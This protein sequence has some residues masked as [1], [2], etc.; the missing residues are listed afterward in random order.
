MMLI[1]TDS[2]IAHIPLEVKF[3]NSDEPY[4]IRTRLG[5]AIRGP[6]PTMKESNDININ[7][8]ESRDML[9]QQQ[10][11]RL[12]T[13]DFND[14]SQ[15]VKSCMSVEDKNA[16]KSM[17]S[18][19]TR[20]DGHYKIGLPWRDGNS[21]FVN[22]IPLAQA[23]LQQLKRKLSSDNNLHDMYR[24][25]VNGY[26]ANGYSSDVDYMVPEKTRVW[27]TPHH[28]VTNVHNASETDK[29][30]VW[31]HGPTFLSKG[32]E[33][34]PKYSSNF[35]PEVSED[36]VEVKRYGCIFSCLTSRAVHLEVTHSLSTDSFIAAS[37]RFISR[38]GLPKKIYSD[39]GTNLVS[40][41]CELRKSIREW[42]QSEIG[43]FML[44]REIEWNFNPPSASHMGG[45]WERM[46]RSTRAILRSLVK[47]QLL[48]DEHILTV[49]TEVEKILNDR[50]ITR[51]SDDP[52]DPP[53][54]TPSM[55]LLLKSNTCI[56]RG[57]FRKED[58]Y[59]KR[60]WRQAQYLADIFWK[61]WI[62]EYIPTLQSRQ[63]W[64]RPQRDIREG[65]IVLVAQ[66]NIPRG[67]WPLGRVESI[68]V[69]RDGHTRSCVV[70]TSMSQFLR[71]ITKLCL[72]E[73]SI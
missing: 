47:E 52:K 8:F 29:L 61:R 28:P 41:D 56:P 27:Y 45:I 69:G 60:R 51:V 32:R 10:I 11:D 64:L 31:L 59:A 3:G 57:I 25:T 39:N 18:T 19:L 48:T 30:N 21:S 7:F 23:R 33:H 1:G 68:N 65:D 38:R 2:P 35:I 14:K 13:A 6:V 46:I 9:L 50:P 42:N 63:K 44:Q 5:W 15:Q 36:D 4:A 12:W 62:R 72:L 26:I 73:C 66:E 34:W 71:P 17:E 49:V 16:M 58:T 70:K 67:Q 43:Q 20:E 22:N 37:Q 54:L 55:I 24:T 53:V 40:G